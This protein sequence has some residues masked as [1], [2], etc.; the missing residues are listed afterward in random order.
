MATGVLPTLS[1]TVIVAEPLVAPETRVMVTVVPDTE[2]T[3]TLVV[4]EEAAEYGRIPPEIVDVAVGLSWL[5][6]ALD[7]NAVRAEPAI[8]AAM[9]AVLPALSMTVIVAVPL[10]AP[11]ARVM[12]TVVPDTGETTVALVVSEEA[13]EYGGVP[14]EIIDVAVG[15]AGLTVTLDGNAV[16]PGLDETVTAIVVA[17]PM[18]SMTVIVSDPVAAPAARVMVTVVPDTETVALVVSEEVAV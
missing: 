11:A 13:A 2:E 6:V 16:I 18:L 5:T 14:P 12:A 15:L 17:L 8:V 1:V 10:V 3:L 7:G 9:V 4:S